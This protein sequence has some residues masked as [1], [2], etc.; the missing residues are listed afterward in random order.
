MAYYKNGKQ[1]RTKTRKEK[2]KE[3]KSLVV[4]QV[5]IRERAAIFLR[6]GRPIAAL[7]FLQALGQ[8]RRSNPDILPRFSRTM[9]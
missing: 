2:A 7:T 3:S 1:K 4:N 6:I 5:L 8:P 9:S